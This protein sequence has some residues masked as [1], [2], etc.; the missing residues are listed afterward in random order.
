VNKTLLAVAAIFLPSV[1]LYPARS[2]TREQWIELG[3]RIHGAFGALSLFRA[4]AI[5]PTEHRHVEAASRQVIFA[6]CVFSEP[7]QALTVL[8]GRKS[9]QPNATRGGEIPIISKIARNLNNRCRKW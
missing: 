6:R 4:S 8:P 1:N 7:S 5:G 9:M 2:E 3:S